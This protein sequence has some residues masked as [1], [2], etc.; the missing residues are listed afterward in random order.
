EGVHGESRNHRSVPIQKPGLLLR[1]SRMKST[2][3]LKIALFP[4]LA[5]AALSPGSAGDRLAGAAIRDAL[6]G[7]TLDGI[8]RGG[9]FFS[10]TVEVDASVRYHDAE[11]ADSG[12]WS[13]KGDTFCTFYDRQP[14]GCFYVRI[15][16]DNCF[17]FSQSNLNRAG[18]EADWDAEGW[19][20]SR[21]P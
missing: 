10:E 20:R 4:V 11:G 2:T 12:Q 18:S 21:P 14:G 13:V 8:Y 6:R 16:G 7:V 17:T 3:R 9:A 15:H 5:L 19:D 1:E